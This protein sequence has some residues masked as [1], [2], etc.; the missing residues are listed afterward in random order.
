LQ[1]SPSSPL[2]QIVLCHD[3]KDIRNSHYYA[4]GTKQFLLGQIWQ[5]ASEILPR[6]RY[7]GSDL[8][9]KYWRV[10]SEFHEAGRVSESDNH[11]IHLGGSA[12]MLRP[13]TP[14]GP[15]WFPRLAQHYRLLPG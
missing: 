4:E 13:L 2:P 10:C 1:C 5:C 6:I 8:P 15:D 11:T 14:Y 12:Q 9:P 7:Q 3:S